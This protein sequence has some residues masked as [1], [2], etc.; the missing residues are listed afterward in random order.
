MRTFGTP[1]L[2]LQMDLEFADGRKQQIVSDESWKLTDKGPIQ[3]NNEFDGEE[4]DARM[5]MPGW[6]SHAFN[7]EKWTTAE[8]L[9][10]PAG[11]MVAEHRHAPPLRQRAHSAAH[12]VKRPDALPPLKWA[13]AWAAWPDARRIAREDRKPPAENCRGLFHFSALDFRCTGQ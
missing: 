11:K 9:S 4:Y 10:A 5:E 12:Y 6:A 13:V 7:A 8:T 3:A 2:L 1:R